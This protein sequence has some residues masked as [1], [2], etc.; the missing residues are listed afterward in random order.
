[1][2]QNIEEYQ[3]GKNQKLAEGQ[4]AAHVEKNYVNSNHKKQNINMVGR[5]VSR[6]VCRYVCNMW[7]KAKPKEREF[8]Q[9]KTENGFAQGRGEI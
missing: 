4:G 8:D 5:Q 6:Q 2:K 7:I 3:K 9:K 1:M